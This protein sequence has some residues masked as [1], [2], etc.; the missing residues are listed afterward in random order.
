MEQQA[1]VRSEVVALEEEL[2]CLNKSQGQ[3]SVPHIANFLSSVPEGV[4]EKNADKWEQ[5]QELL[6]S[7]EAPDE[8]EAT[9]ADVDAVNLLSE[10]E[11]P[12]GPATH[13][14][15]QRAASGPYGNVARMDFDAGSFV[16]FMAQYLQGSSFDEVDSED[17]S[18]CPYQVSGEAGKAFKRRQHAQDMFDKYK[19]FKSAKTGP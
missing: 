15:P 3:G 13:G 4:K 18:H 2:G 12:F 7:L 17:E 6:R 14:K 1:A 10:N 9:I 8:S 11:A 5:V 16:D 19:L